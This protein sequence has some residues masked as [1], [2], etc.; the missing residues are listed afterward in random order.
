MKV[1][2]WAKEVVDIA[3]VAIKLKFMDNH[4]PQSLTYPE[5]EPDKTAWTLFNLRRSFF[6][7]KLAKKSFVTLKR[8]LMLNLICLKTMKKWR[9][10]STQWTCW[11]SNYYCE[12]MV[13]II[14][15]WIDRRSNKMN[16]IFVEML[17]KLCFRITK[18]RKENWEISNLPKNKSKSSRR[19]SCKL[20]ERRIE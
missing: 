13:E 5:Q 8:F 12:N 9:T 2:Y 16:V 19:K 4:R 7:T 10:R 11:V 18:G 17:R 6:S 20:K 1:L 3:S 15:K 14:L